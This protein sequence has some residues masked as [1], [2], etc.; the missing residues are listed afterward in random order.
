MR[1]SLFIQ[2]HCVV[3]SLVALSFHILDGIYRNKNV[4]TNMNTAANESLNCKNW[5]QNKNPIHD[6]TCYDGSS[7]GGGISMRVYEKFA[8]ESKRG[9]G[10]HN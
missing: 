7:G 5:M 8:C 2:Y 3:P 6:E 4:F 1:F 10:I 9:T